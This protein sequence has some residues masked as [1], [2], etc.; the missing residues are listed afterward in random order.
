LWCRFCADLTFNFGQKKG[1]RFN[2]EFGRSR[3]RCGGVKEV[4]D[5]CDAEEVQED[6]ECNPY[7]LPNADAT[8][9]WQK[10]EK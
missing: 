8:I 9:A 6:A 1:D 2:N 7:K 3:G 5:P 4:E 10:G